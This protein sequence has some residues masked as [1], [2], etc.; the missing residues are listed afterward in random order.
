MTMDMEL[1]NWIGESALSY[2]HDD[3]EYY[4]SD[5]CYDLMDYVDEAMDSY[6]LPE[7]DD[8]EDIEEIIYFDIYR[9]AE[10]MIE[11]R[12]ILEQEWERDVRDRDRE[13]WRM[14]I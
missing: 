3:L 5:A 6:E 8:P 2:L 1:R 9:K 11:E 12:N 4:G 13:Y 10:K 7:E 14:V